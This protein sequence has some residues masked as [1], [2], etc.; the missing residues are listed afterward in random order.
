M[1]KPI[2]IQV[3][4]KTKGTRKWAILNPYTGRG[5]PLDIDLLKEHAAALAS[6]LNFSDVIQLMGG[7]EAYEQAIASANA[8]KKASA[9]KG[10]AKSIA[11]VPAKKVAKKKATA[12]KGAAK[13]KTVK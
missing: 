5:S 10:S 11:K 1:K 2:L 3:D 4:R 9:K 7:V 12:K 6:K 13:K 8:P